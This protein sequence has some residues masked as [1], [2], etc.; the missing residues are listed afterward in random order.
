M[1]QNQLETLLYHLKLMHFNRGQKIFSTGDKPDGV[2]LIQEGT[3]ELTK[4]GKIFESQ[5]K[6]VNAMKVD[7][8]AKF[9]LRKQTKV[10]KD[11]SRRTVRL[12]ILG[13]GELFGLEECQTKSSKTLRPRGYTVN[14]LENNS[15][16]IFMSHQIMSEKVLSDPRA[17]QQIKY[18]CALKEFF[19]NSR[20]LQHQQ[21]VWNGALTSIRQIENAA[22]KADIEFD[23]QLKRDF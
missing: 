21:T 4:P 18:D 16:V 23:Q 19:H 8:M 17:E 13:T 22:E 1:T 3:F 9:K 15:K 7:P 11:R 6:I 12:A 10:V 14:C 2:Y 5:E 20:E